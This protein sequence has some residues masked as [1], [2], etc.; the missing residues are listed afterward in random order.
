MVAGNPG[1]DFSWPPRAVSTTPEGN[2]VGVK[3]VLSEMP[4]D[5]WWAGARSMWAPVVSR[6]T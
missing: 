5:W 4:A 3:L 6:A 2:Q 1:C